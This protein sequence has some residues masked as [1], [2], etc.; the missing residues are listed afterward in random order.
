MSE[1]DHE[2]TFQ[3]S[4]YVARSI[5]YEH[6]AKGMLLSAIMA[7]PLVLLAFATGSIVGFGV[8]Q[9]LIN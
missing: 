6:E 1:H 7:V 4:E 5:I 2:A 8:A 3:I 9:A